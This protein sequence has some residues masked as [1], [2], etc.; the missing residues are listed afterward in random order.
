MPCASSRSSSVSMSSSSSSSFATI[1][2]SSVMWTQPCSSPCSIRN[3]IGSW[4]MAS[5]TP[6]SRGSNAV[7]AERPYRFQRILTPV[8]VPAHV[9]SPQFRGAALVASPGRS[10]R[11]ASYVRDGMARLRA[12]ARR[13]DRQRARPDVTSIGSERHVVALDPDHRP[14]Q[15]PRRPAAAGTARTLPERRAA[16]PCD[17]E[18]LADRLHAPLLHPH[19]VGGDRAPE[20]RPRGRAEEDQHGRREPAPSGDPEGHEPPHP[21]GAPRV[22]GGGAGAGR[23]PGV[24]DPADAPPGGADAAAGAW[25]PARRRRPV[26]EAQEALGGFGGMAFAVG[27]RWT[28]AGKDAGRP[29]SGSYR[30]N[31]GRS[32]RASSAARR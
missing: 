32:L 10:R 27:V 28:F 16:P 26:A 21:G 11:H 30:V 24:A 8:E 7:T 1:S 31:R 25:R 19:L 29:C 9:V 22:H 12:G 23:R 2:Y 15:R 18:A 20:P 17:R 14:R 4:A 13:R 6:P 5:G 3:A